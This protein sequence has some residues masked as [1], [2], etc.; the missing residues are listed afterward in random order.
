MNRASDYRVL[1]APIASFF[2]SCQRLLSRQLGTFVAPRQPIWR[3]SS[4]PMSRRPKHIASRTCAYACD[5]R[6]V[7]AWMSARRKRAH[8]HLTFFPWDSG[9]VGRD[10]KRG[11]R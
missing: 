8:A 5:V 7:S 11:E 2:A 3:A 6:D 10:K 4:R 9:T 1:A